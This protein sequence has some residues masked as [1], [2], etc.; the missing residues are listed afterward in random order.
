M[1]KQHTLATK[2][3]TND[4]A[5]P[6]VAPMN[7]G[8]GLGWNTELKQY[9]INVNKGNGIV[10]NPDG[11]VGLQLS[12]DAGNQL[13]LRPNGVFFGNIPKP[14]NS[15]FFVS[16]SGS[17]S[18]NGSRETPLRTMHEALS[19]IANNKTNGY[20]RIYLHSGQTF[21]FPQTRVWLPQTL[22]QIEISYYNDPK[23]PDNTQVK[24]IYRPYGAEDLK[25]PTLIFTDFDTEHSGIIYSGFETGGTFALGLY[26]L[27]VRYDQLRAGGYAGL[28]FYHD[29]LIFEGCHIYLNSKS[30]GIGS[31][32]VVRLRG[33]RLYN[34]SRNVYNLFVSD[35][36]PNIWVFDPLDE[37]GIDPDGSLSFTPMKGN[38]K[39]V[40]YAETVVVLAAIDRNTKTT[41]GFTTN[42]DI[43]ANS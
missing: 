10:L 22:C 39:Q 27:N 23:Y 18:N 31:A 3:E 40:L 13:E 29:K 6:V 36:T 11:T 33:N 35:L 42:W 12:P 14:E 5:I 17:D 25:R 19:R 9:E 16:N 37:Q 32:K 2:Q 43:F 24:G 20:Y 4:G 1:A 41:F 26:G 15:T 38:E 28:G 7:M 30:V 34:T 8:K 21:S